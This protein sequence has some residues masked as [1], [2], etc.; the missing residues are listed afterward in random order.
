[1]R[2][3]LRLY[4]ARWRQRYGDE[5]LALIDTQPL[6]S[7]V[8]LDIVRGAFDAWLR[9]QIGSAG[10]AVP[11][12]GAQPSRRPRRFDKF[13]ARSRSALQ[14]ASDEARLLNNEF[15]GTEHLLL[16]LLHDQDSVAARV[17]ASLN[18]EPDT[19]RSAVQARVAS[20]AV[21]ELATRGLTPSAKR[22]IELGVDEARRARCGYVGTEHLLLGLVREGEGVAATVLTDL[23]GADV[24]RLRRTVA[25]VLTDGPGPRLWRTGPGKR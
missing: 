13:T 23:T 21:R 2:W 5:F 9:P 7:A 17:L 1:M 10:L 11:A 14:F 24:A 8:V 15:I 19:L 16:G 6:T 3:L 4:P 18:V 12:S 20:R 22:A 25:G